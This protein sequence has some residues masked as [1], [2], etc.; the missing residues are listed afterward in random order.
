MFFFQYS[1]GYKIELKV[2]DVYYI[3]FTI[4][5]LYVSLM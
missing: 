1:V 3:G 4:N 2:L 5:W